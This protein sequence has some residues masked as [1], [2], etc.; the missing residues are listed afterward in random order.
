MLVPASHK[1]LYAVPRPSHT[2]M[3][4]DIVRYVVA[5]PMLLP[6]NDDTRRTSALSPLPNFTNWRRHLTPAAGSVVIYFNQTA[7]GVWGWKGS[8]YH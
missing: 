2:S 3:D 5:L 7:H 6:C 4:L 1:Q 8:C